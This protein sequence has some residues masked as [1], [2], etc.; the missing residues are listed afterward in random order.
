MVQRLKYEYHDAGVIG[1]RVGP[2]REV[3]ITAELDR[4]A[5]GR[6]AV[7][8][9]R[10]GG[11]ANFA[12]VEEYFRGVMADVG[13]SYVGRIDGLGYDESVASTSRDIVLRVELDLYGVVQIRCQ[14]VTEKEVRADGE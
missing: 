4:C 7:I 13:E 9:I 2:R 5:S 3:T 8:H 10:F 1:V 14:N 6:S 12:Q 11:I